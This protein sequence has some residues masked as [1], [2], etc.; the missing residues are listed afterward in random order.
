MHKDQ[1]KNMHGSVHIK[2][3]EAHYQLPLSILKD[4]YIFTWVKICLNTCKIGKKCTRF[5]K[6]YLSQKRQQQ[7]ME[8]IE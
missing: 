5:Q 6:I 7:V 1:E 4:F 8:W 3:L 2:T